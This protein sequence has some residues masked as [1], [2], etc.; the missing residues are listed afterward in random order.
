MP[1]SKKAFI[2]LFGLVSIF[3]L[4]KKFSFVIKP[5]SN[6]ERDILN[7]IFNCSDEQLLIDRSILL[8]TMSF[9]LQETD[10]LD[11]KLIDF[12]RSL[13]HIPSKNEKINLKQKERTDFSQMGQSKFIDGV[14]NSK[15]NGFFIEAG[16]FNGEDHSV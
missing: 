1:N 11:P 14:L 13:I 15:T 16:G 9:M 2:I 12:V 6:P 7:D 5:K 4:L 3:F 8:Q 10:E